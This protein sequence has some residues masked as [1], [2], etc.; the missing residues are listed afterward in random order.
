MLELIYHATVR[1]VR[2]SHGN[3]I[4]GLAMS[5]LQTVILVAVF[6]FLFELLGMRGNSI[7]GDFDSK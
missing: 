5:I 7:R 2:K 6:F 1:S 4:I 3:A